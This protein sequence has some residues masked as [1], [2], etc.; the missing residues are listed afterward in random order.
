M[1]A[2][3][4][5]PLQRMIEHVVIPAAVFGQAPAD[6]E[7]VV[8]VRVFAHVPDG[9]LEAGRRARRDVL[10]IHA[11]AVHDVIFHQRELL[12]HVDDLRLAGGQAQIVAQGGVG[13]VVD[14]GDDRAAQVER[15]AIGFLVVQRSKNAFA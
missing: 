10:H 6:L 11:Q 9:D 2:S 12:D 7:L 1:S 3:V 14:A 4:I 8:E 15:D 13:L 5:S